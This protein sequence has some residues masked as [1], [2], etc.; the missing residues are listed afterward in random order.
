MR[1]AKIDHKTFDIIVVLIHSEIEIIFFSSENDIEGRLCIEIKYEWCISNNFVVHTD[2]CR[3]RGIKLISMGLGL[4]Y[5]LF[6]IVKKYEIGDGGTDAEKDDRA[7]DESNFCGQRM[8][9]CNDR[10]RRSCAGGMVLAALVVFGAIE[11]FQSTKKTLHGIVSVVAI[12]LQGF[13][14]N[15]I[16]AFPPFV[17]FEVAR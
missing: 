6:L 8:E 16:N 13:L 15:G 2:F 10:E 5:F 17:A 7:N 12:F 14:E 3:W 4:L 11:L 9:V 1:L